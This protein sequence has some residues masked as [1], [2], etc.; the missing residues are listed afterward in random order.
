MATPRLPSLGW[1][2]FL[3]FS[4]YYFVLDRNEVEARREIFIY[5]QTAEVSTIIHEQYRTAYHF[6]PSRNW[7]NDPNG[8]MYYN[9]IYHLF[10]QYN[11]Y[12]ALWGNITWGHSV[13]TD[14]INW[15]QLELALERDELFDINGCCSGSITILP[16]NKPVILYTGIDSEN[17]QV[18]NVAYPKNLS[19][20]FLQEWTKPKFNPIMAPVGDIDAIEFRD[21]TTGWLGADGLWRV[22]VGAKL[23]GMGAAILYRS[24]DFVHWVRAEHLLH[25]SKASGVW[26]CPDFYPVLLEGRQGLDTSTNSGGVKHVLKMSLQD[27]LQD[28][29]MLGKYDVEKDIFLP[30]EE[31]HNYMLWSRI[32]YGNY[33]A[34]KSFFDANKQ[35]RI[36]WAW[37]NESDSLSDAVAKGWAGIQATPRT[38][39]LDSN[40]RQLVQ[41]PIEELESL[42]GKEV[43]LHDIELKTGSLIEIEGV[44]TSQAD[45][46]IDFQLPSLERAEPFDPS[47]LLDP[48]KLCGEK[49]ASIHGGIGPFGLF[50]LAS[51]DLKQHTAVFFRV[52]KAQNKYM[53]LMC[54][55]QR[56]SSLRSVLYKPAYGGFLDVD[57]EKGRR[58]SL[59]TLID[60]SIIESFGGGGRASIT[61]RVYP[62][63]HLENGTHLYAF[64]SGS[65]AVKI[66]KLKA[67]D[68]AK[69][70]INI[71]KQGDFYANADSME[72]GPVIA[73]FF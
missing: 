26:E 56:R 43:H 60:H 34:A 63:L 16:G 61:A 50:V 3:C 40:G 10:Y 30:D 70:Q 67:W 23:R 42:R 35:R 8:P 27:T 1:V 18:Q 24:E 5:P 37:S 7:M 38:L 62:E 28:Y 69:P 19:D 47:W 54:S 68:M 64:N 45:V 58:I 65:E 25:S 71:K 49:D 41:W 14:L 33:Y 39:W 51:H 29:Y 20:P 31:L 53:I 21:P 9:G 52:Y 44:K 46:E 17:R 32:D 36:I 57:I 48:Q 66:S 13:S 55:D 59:R 22:A 15:V 6:Q 73:S 72:S 12:S 11:P 2:F 4:S